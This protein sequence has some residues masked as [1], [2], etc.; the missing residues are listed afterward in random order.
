[1]L[2]YSFRR[3]WPTSKLVVPVVVM[4]IYHGGYGDKIKTKTNKIITAK[5][6]FNDF[7]INKGCW[8]R[9]IVNQVSVALI[10]SAYAFMQG[11]KGSN[12]ADDKKVVRRSTAFFAVEFNLTSKGAREG[13]HT[14]FVIF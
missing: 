2:D 4:G 10:V 5:S 13:A 3:G 12:P 9:L 8:L 1:M 14:L 7:V 6:T 11:V